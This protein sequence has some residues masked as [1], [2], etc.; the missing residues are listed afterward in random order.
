[1]NNDDD[2]D[3]HIDEDENLDNDKNYNNNKNNILLQKAHVVVELVG[4]DPKLGKLQRAVD[5]PGLVGRVAA[6][7][8]EPV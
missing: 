6:V 5:L 4:D 8:L 2:H 7:P 3:N 1:M